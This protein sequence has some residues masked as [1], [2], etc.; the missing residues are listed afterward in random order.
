MTI[1]KVKFRKPVEP[2]DRVEF[3][4]TQTQ[5]PPQH[6]VV[7][8]RGEGRRRAC[9]RGR[10]QRHAGNGLM[11]TFIHTTAIVEDGAKIGAGVED[12]TVLHGRPGGRTRRGL[13][14]GQPRGASPA[15]RRSG[16]RTRIF[17]FASI[18]HIPQDLKYRGEPS[19]LTIGSDCTIPRRRHDES[20]H[21]RRRPEDGDRR[22]LRLPGQF[23]CRPRHEGRQRRHPVEQRHAGGPCHGGRF[24][25]LR[26]R[27]GRHPVCPRRLARLRRRPDGT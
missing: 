27:R 3:H 25:D 16:P 9:L 6:V 26:R 14:A 23:P 17:P 10:G 19:T 20:R 8:G 11:E 4:M 12:R 5:Q 21:R 15:A 2:G 13:R 18:G 7:Q 1:D 22:S 24:R